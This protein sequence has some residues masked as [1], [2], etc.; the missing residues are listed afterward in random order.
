MSDLLGIGLSGVRAYRTALAAVADN[1]ANAE[2][3]GYARRDVRISD[4]VNASAKSP[5][6]AELTG[7]GIGELTIL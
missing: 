1:V 6:Y 7:H 4:G 2:N 3:P 5:I